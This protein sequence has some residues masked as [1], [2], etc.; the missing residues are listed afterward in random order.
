MLPDEQKEVTIKAKTTKARKNQYHFNLKEYLH[1]IVGVD[2]TEIDGLEENTVLTI[3]AVVGLNMHKWPAADHFVSWLNLASR[4]RIRW[5]S[6]WSSKTFY[7]QSCYA[8][9]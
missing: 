9:F 7:K 8:G 6:D 1:K 2:L 4:P 5:K 3:I